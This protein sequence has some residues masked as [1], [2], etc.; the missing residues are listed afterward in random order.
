M[1]GMYRK[2][3]TANVLCGMKLFKGKGF[4][5]HYSVVYILPLPS[6]RISTDIYVKRNNEWNLNFSVSFSSK[7]NG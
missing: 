6:V 4:F 3:C 2:T 5:F 1:H 7:Q